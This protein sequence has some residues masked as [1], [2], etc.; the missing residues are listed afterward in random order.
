MKY[1]V[2]HNRG[3]VNIFESSCVLFCVGKICAV[4]GENVIRL[5]EIMLP[6]FKRD[7]GLSNMG[8][9]PRICDKYQL[10]NKSNLISCLQSATQTKLADYRFV[11]YPEMEHDFFEKNIKQDTRQG[12][13]VEY[14]P[15][16]AGAQ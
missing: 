15:Q 11:G 3:N 12:A 16:A 6:E 1:I 9:T 2:Q 5:S 10:G 13:A 8:R 4:M 7:M 14:V